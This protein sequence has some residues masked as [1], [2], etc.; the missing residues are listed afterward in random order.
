MAD[1]IG[2]GWAFPVAV[3]ARGRISLARGER[4][5]EEA[6][7]II[8]L[9]PRGE[10]P[11]RPE[12]GCK[13]HDLI[14][15]PNNASTIGLAR[16]YVEQ[17]LARWEP[18]ITVREVRAYPDSVASGRLLVE[19]DYQIRSTLDRRT[20]VFPFYQIPGEAGAPA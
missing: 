3:D 12:F 4:D 9:T 14:F 2:S 19:I 18:R 20:L 7:K 6:M 11:M 10:R 5:I 17:A 16:R 8:L 13:I 1:I 15:A